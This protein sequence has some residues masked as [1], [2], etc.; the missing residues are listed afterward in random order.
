MSSRRPSLRPSKLWPRTGVLLTLLALALALR[1]VAAIAMPLFSQEAYYWMYA[2]HL[3]WGY[4]DH[5]P[6]VA[7]VIWLGTALFGDTEWGVRSAN[8]AAMLSASVVLFL[9]ARQWFSKRAALVSALSLQ[10]LPIYFLTGLVTTMDGALL[11]SW[12]ACLA[13]FSVAVRT[14]RAWAWVV[15]GISMGA[16]MLSKYTGVFLGV[17]GLLA[18]AWHPAWRAQFRR[19]WPYVAAA[20]AVACFAPVVVW[21]AQHDWAS[22]RFQAAGR[23]VEPVRWWRSMAVFPLVWLAVLTPV[24]LLAG[25]AVWWRSL[26]RLARA[27]PALVL[28]TSFSLPL[29]LVF[30]ANA[31]RQQV[32]INWLLPAFP[33]LLPAAANHVIAEWRG[34]R[35]VTG[36]IELPPPLSVTAAGCLLAC[37][38]VA[39]PLAFGWARFGGVRG[40]ND[41]RALAQ[42]VDDAVGTLRS[43]TGREPLVIGFGHYKMAS[44][45]AF[46]RAP[47]A[48]PA[49]ASSTTTSGWIL[50][51]IGLSFPYWT[52]RE[53]WL[54]T[55]CVLVSESPIDP[56][57]AAWFDRV[58]VLPSPVLANGSHSGLAICRGLRAKPGPPQIVNRTA[59]HAAS[60]HEA[61]RPE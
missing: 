19:P 49:R 27:R 5:P 46:Y 15:A 10:V 3:D 38:V 56:A 57:S 24:P 22:F 51:D 18:V 13:A 9:F 53:R 12:A 21:N 16:A 45:I 1:L 61:S 4:F 40:L 26:R 2:Q 55:D 41:W 42:R 50:D 32:H 8:L 11:L 35:S 29:F 6:M 34:W 44:L 30:L 52:T 59:A 7:W 54:G 37:I 48:P 17:G 14:G 60:S 33:S 36:R 23:F 28:A 47:L 20:I 58:E 31:P 25:V 43:E 39:V